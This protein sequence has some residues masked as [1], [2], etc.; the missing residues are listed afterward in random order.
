MPHT[1]IDR[2]AVDKRSDRKKNELRDLGDESAVRDYLRFLVNFQ[3][4]HLTEYDEERLEIAFISSV[5]RWL[6]ATNVDSGTLVQFG[7]PRRIL[8]MARL[9]EISQS[10]VVRRG[11]TV[12]PFSTATLSQS[13]SISITSVRKTM[14]LDER[15]GL[16][17]MC[18]V[19][20][21]TIFYRLLA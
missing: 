21:K 10:D 11:Y 9:K 14:N 5:N 15:N 18:E 8:N 12:E 3:S 17:E 2:P 19:D 16:I 13:L 7:V 4:R 1:P 6:K 20:G